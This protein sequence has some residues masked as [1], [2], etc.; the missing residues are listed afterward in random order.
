M[1]ALAVGAVLASCALLAFVTSALADQIHGV[2]VGHT[3]LLKERTQT[4]NCTLSPLEPSQRRLV[5]L[6]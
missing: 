4:S 1:R 3:V 6:W 2:Q 5:V